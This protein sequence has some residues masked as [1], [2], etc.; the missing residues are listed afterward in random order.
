MPWLISCEKGNFHLRRSSSSRF[1]LSLD[2]G[3]A[4]EKT[5]GKEAGQAQRFP[6]ADESKPGLGLLA[7]LAGDKM[8]VRVRPR[9]SS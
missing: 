7:P 6:K 4:K 8:F 5:D 2:T 9:S 1:D 3:V